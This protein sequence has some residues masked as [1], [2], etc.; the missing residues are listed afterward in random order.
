MTVEEAIESAKK[1]KSQPV[2]A[3]AGHLPVGLLPNTNSPWQSSVQNQPKL[4]SIKG[5]NGED[6]AEIIQGQTIHTVKLVAGARFQ[7][8]EVMAFDSDSVTLT[9]R[10]NSS[11]SATHS[12]QRKKHGKP[13][14]KLYVAA[15][16]HSIDNYRIPTENDINT[17]Q[18]QAAADLPILP[19]APAKN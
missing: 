6:T 4:W 15:K 12:A 8:W 18:R 19:A 13:P 3:K 14:L 17:Q 2:I 5:I 11:K 16:G 7:Q 9:E 1:K 10:D